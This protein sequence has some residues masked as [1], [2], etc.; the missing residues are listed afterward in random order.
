MAKRTTRWR[1]LERAVG[2]FVLLMLAVAGAGAAYQALSLRQERRA[3]PPPGRMVDV[4]GTRTHLYCTG[5]GSPT[6]I[7]ESGMSD[8]WIVWYKVQP[9]ISRLTRTCSYDRAGI[10]WS[11][12][13]PRPRTSRAI[14]EELHA[15]LSAA[16]VSGPYVLVGHSLGGSHVRVYAGVYPEEV[17]G[18]VLVDPTH[19]DQ[20]RRFPGFT[21]IQRQFARDIE[22][23][24]WV[25]P[26]GL[27][28]WMGWCGNSAWCRG[29]TPEIH[30]AFRAFD[31]T[32]KQKRAW[33]AEG[34]AIEESLSQAAAAGSLGSRPL[35]VISQAPDPGGPAGQD[36]RARADLLTLAELHEDLARLSSRGRR[37]VASG[38]GHYIFV[39][40][41]DVVITAVRDVVAAVRTP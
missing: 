39:D 13:S 34:R 7:L 31:C 22:K 30:E 16:R 2:V 25:M 11:D 21:A 15:L 38:S 32:V 27:P 33:L 37:V 23:L 9:A 6:V 8:P 14:A 18:M 28:R 35:V 17:A 40:R 26:L 1:R 36:P 41:P 10:G 19:P 5:Q 20:A 29:A 4:G 12:P 3:H 24:S